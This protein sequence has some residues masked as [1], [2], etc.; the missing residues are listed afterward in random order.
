MKVNLVLSG[1]ASRGIAHI[2]VIKALGDMGFQI[3]AISGVSAGALVGAFYCAGYT[4]EEMLRI[5]KATDWIK[6]IRPKVPRYGFFSLSKAEK[7]LRKYL[8]VE[9]IEN[10]K[11]ELYIGVLDIKSGRS[12]HFNE[13]PLYPIL[14]GSC[15]LPGIFEPIK[16]E[17]YILI[18]GGVTNNLPVEPLLEKEGILIGADVNPTNTLEKVRSIF[19]II[20][21][22]FL[23]AV[24]SN[25][26]KRKELCHVIIQP[27]LQNYSV[28]DFWRAQ[29]IY[30]LGY[31]K[32]L[33]VMSAYVK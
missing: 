4:P 30:T 18:D 33:E 14:L 20:A 21:R 23:L 16:Y 29:E 13:G 24:R 8:E 3:E 6:V 31:K 1:G 11:R 2:G 15:A 7:F 19:H 25:V 28:I 22:S 5:V 26:E 9:R 32:T 17:D 10:L 27:E 12:F